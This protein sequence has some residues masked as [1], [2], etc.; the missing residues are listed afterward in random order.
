[1]GDA[2]LGTL[3][4]LAQLHLHSIDA[5]YAVDEKD[6]DEYERDLSPCQDPASISRCFIRLP[7]F[8]PY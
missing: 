8:I 5:I 1:M 4:R 2:L 6:Q 3:L 7:T